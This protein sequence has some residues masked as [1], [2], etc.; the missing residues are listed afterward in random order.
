MMQLHKE[1]EAKKLRMVGKTYR[2]FKGNLYKVIDLAVSSDGVPLV[3]YHN[4]SDVAKIW[5]R[6]LAEFESPVDRDKYPDVEQAERF[7]L[8]DQ[9]A[10]FMIRPKDCSSCPFGV[11]TYSHPCWASENPNT[12]GYICQLKPVNDRKVE[13]FHYDESP[14]ISNCPLISAENVRVDK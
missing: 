8:V 7:K 6:P 1:L 5:A 3:L 4:L 12:K 11:C 10:A 13:D 9:V 2:H 14:L